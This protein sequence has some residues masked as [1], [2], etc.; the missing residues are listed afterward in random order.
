MLP[1]APKGE[2]LKAILP[3]PDFVMAETLLDPAFVKL[4]AE[5]DAWHAAR[6]AFMMERLEAGRH[7][8]TDPHFW[9]GY[10]ERPAPGLPATS[11]PHAYDA[12]LRMRQRITLLVV[13]GVPTFVVVWLVGRSVRARRRKA[14]R[15][16]HW[17]TEAAGGFR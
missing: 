17:S 8:D 5:A 7:P 11:V 10:T 3:K 15:A 13:L 1:D 4:R 2:A 9:D 16:D 14:L 6:T 12:W